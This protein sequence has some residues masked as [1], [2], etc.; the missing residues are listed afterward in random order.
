[1]AR[2]WPGALRGA[3]L[4]VPCNRCR[5]LQRP[6]CDCSAACEPGCPGSVRKPHVLA[7]PCGRDDQ[8]AALLGRPLLQASRVGRIGSFL[9]AYNSAATRRR[10]GCNP[11]RAAPVSLTM[12]AKTRA[13]HRLE[14]SRLS[15]SL[16]TVPRDLLSVA[17]TVPQLP[18]FRAYS[19]CCSADRDIAY[20]TK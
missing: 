10:G 4:Q 8:L 20:H 1:M 2:E 13:R 5:A 17:T 14:S 6:H 18:H 7:A 16:G 12:G 3:R 9:Y 19:G 11:G 15:E